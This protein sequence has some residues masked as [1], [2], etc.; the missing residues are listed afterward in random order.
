MLDKDGRQ[1][2]KV[3]SYIG[4]RTNNFAE[5]AAMIRALR[6]AIYFK[7]EELKIR[8]DS[9]LIVKQIGGEYRVKNDQIKKLYDEAMTLIKSIKKFKIEHVPRTQNDKA[10]YLA[11]KAVQ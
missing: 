9:E 7:T 8:T 11:R 10:D 4:R 2:G 6:I 3:S 1:M 5:Y